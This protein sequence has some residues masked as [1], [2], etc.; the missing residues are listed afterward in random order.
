MRQLNDQGLTVVELLVVII[1]SSVVMAVVTAFGLN[2]WANSTKLQSNQETLVSRL[3]SGDYL[4]RAINA[5][6]G[7]I[8]QNNLPD[9]HTGKVDP[10]DVTGEHWLPIHAIPATTS[11]GAAGTITPVVYFNRPSIDISKNIVMNGSIPFQ[12]DIILYLNGT[13][14]QLLARTIANPSAT[15]NRAKTTCPASLAT[16]T[17]P[18]DTIIADD[19][20]GV[21]MRYFS[22]SGNLIDHS[23]II[24]SSSGKFIGPDF[25]SV[26]VI[27]FNLRLSRKARIQRAGDTSNQTIIRVALRN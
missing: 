22:R 2:Y 14:K 10:A 18:A 11:M 23:S 1:V 15:N 24:D 21:T 19:I 6:S 25:P 9:L 16:S 12:D 3:N 8:I 13:T 26:E 27:E 4:R 7:F 5:A 20:T 17:C